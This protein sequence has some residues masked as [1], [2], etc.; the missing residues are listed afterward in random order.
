[1]KILVCDDIEERGDQTRQQIEDVTDHEVELLSEE[2]L[3]AE[4]EALIERTRA[5][6]A[7]P[8]RAVPE[9][10]TSVFDQRF[11]M[12][13]LDNNLSRLQI[14]GARYT[15]E[16]IIG[17]VR[18][19]VDIPYIVSLNK[20]PHVDFDLRDLIGDDETQA[21]VALN[22]EH[23][24]NPA[25]WSGN[26]ADATDGFAPWYWP[27]LNDVVDRR[28]KQIQFVLNHL[29]EPILRS[30]NFPRFGPHYLSRRAKGALSPEAASATRVTFKRFFEQACRSLPIRADREKLSKTASNGGPVRAAV[31]RVVASELDRW[32]RRDVLG[33]QAVLVDVPHLL[34]RM[35]FLLG[36]HADDLDRW[37]EAVLTTDPPYGLAREMYKKHLEKARFPHAAWTNAPCFWWSTLKTNAELNQMFFQENPQWADVVFCEDTSQFRLANNGKRDAPME[38]AAELEG[39]WSRRH[40]AH[41]SGQ[42]YAP[43]SRFAK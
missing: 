5:V 32:I 36:S 7:N 41:L 39:T 12:A 11:Q 3:A 29:E 31:S 4:I 26:P 27:A 10:E 24:S 42:H 6:L 33:P 37:N 25:L 15:A 23:L 2:R 14:A 43:K 40:V 13:I 19:F 22:S 8:Q 17:Y 38:F 30:M 16:S 34:M 1:M 18:A 20:N 9:N 28:R 21:D 35:P